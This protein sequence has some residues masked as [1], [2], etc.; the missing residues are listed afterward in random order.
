MYLFFSDSFSFWRLHTKNCAW[1]LT[2]KRD[3]FLFCDVFCPIVSQRAW[4]LDRA[5][6]ARQR[7][8]NIANVFGFDSAPFLDEDLSVDRV[9]TRLVYFYFFVGNS[10]IFPK[11]GITLPIGSEKSTPFHHWACHLCRRH[12]RR[13]KKRSGSPLFFLHPFYGSVKWHHQIPI[14]TLFFYASHSKRP[15]TGTARQRRRQ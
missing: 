14:A 7:A 15:C 13:V 9:T 3:W 8:T 12:R 10:N 5:H 4:W 2:K 1:A 11:K 6:E